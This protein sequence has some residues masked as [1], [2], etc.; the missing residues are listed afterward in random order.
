MKQVSEDIIVTAVGEL[1]LARDKARRVS[2]SKNHS[3]AS[4]WYIDSRYKRLYREIYSEGRLDS[5]A[6]S[7]NLWF[8][9]KLTI[10]EAINKYASSEWIRCQATRL[11]G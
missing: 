7:S 6:P 10:L 9:D 1:P 2:T 5:Q 4:V 8:S 11:L 3:W